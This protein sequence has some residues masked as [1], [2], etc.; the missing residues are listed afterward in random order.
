MTIHT[1]D[2]LHTTHRRLARRVGRLERAELVLAKMRAGAA[3]H[4]QH[5]KQGPCWTLSNGTPVPDSIAKLVTG[6]SSVTGVGDALF[7]DC[8][9]QTFRW[10]S[11]EQ[12]A[13]RPARDPKSG[14]HQVFQQRRPSW[15]R[16]RS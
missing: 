15:P 10:W 3:L 9:A 6:S 4:L 12:R 11:A 8:L 7:R 5:T 1:P 16:S 14:G 13:R 2:S